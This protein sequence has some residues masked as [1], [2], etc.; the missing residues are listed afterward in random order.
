M[1]VFPNP[2]LIMGSLPRAAMGSGIPP[3]AVE[4]DIQTNGTIPSLM[5]MLWMR[6]GRKLRH[7]P[8]TGAQSHP[9]VVFKIGHLGILSAIKGKLEPDQSNGVVVTVAT[10]DH[11]LLSIYDEA[12]LYPS[13]KLVT[14]LTVLAESL[15]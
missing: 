9:G 10:P 1:A 12:G 7:V 14:Q 15:K 13:D 4:N 2:D 6:I 3:W 5:G 11:L 8:N